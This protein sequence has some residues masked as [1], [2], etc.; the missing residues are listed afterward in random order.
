[1]ASGLVKRITS[2]I[3]FEALISDLSSRGLIAVPP[4][5]VDREVE[6]AQCRVC[7]ALGVDQ[8]VLWQESP[9]SRV[10]SSRPTSYMRG[11]KATSW[12][13]APGTVPRVG[14]RSWPATRFASLQRT[15]CR[16]RPPSTRRTP[17]SPGIKSSLTLPISVGGESTVACVAFN[18]TRAE[19]DWP[20]ELVV[21]LQL[22]AQIFGDAL[23]LSAPTRPSG[24]PRA[25]GTGSRL[26]G[27]SAVAYEYDS[28]VFWVTERPHV[29]RLHAGRVI[30]LESLRLSSSRRLGAAAECRRAGR[31]RE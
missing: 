14:S 8:S 12:A 31:P 15:N 23:V 6:D 2:G 1:M 17:A 3:E 13:D 20:D 25:V 21:R 7:E 10:P 28:G 22:V 19:R 9:A 24:E 5:D 18:T 4:D 16:P 29:V 11:G 30:T 26:G 27:G